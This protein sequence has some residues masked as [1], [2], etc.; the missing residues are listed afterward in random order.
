MGPAATGNSRLN[1]LLGVA[2]RVRMSTKTIARQPE[3][4]EVMATANQRGGDCI[5]RR[6]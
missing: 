2:G 5:R 3:D 1:I 6:P 4:S